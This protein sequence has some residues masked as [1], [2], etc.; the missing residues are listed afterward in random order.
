MIASCKDM[1]NMLM[2]VPGTFSDIMSYIR[3]WAM[4][5]AGSSISNTVNTFAAPM[6]GNSALLVFG[7]LLFSFGHVFNMVLNAMSVLVH[8]VRLNTLEFT[9]HMGLEW[10][11]FVYKPFAKRR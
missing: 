9:N 11:G 3:L 2:N 5:V 6:M 4:G 8:G 7:I 10:T 1:I